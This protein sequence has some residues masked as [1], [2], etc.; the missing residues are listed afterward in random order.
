MKKKETDTF[1]DPQSQEMKSLVAHVKRLN[2]K[3]IKEYKDWCKDNGLSAG[4]HKSS[5]VR[6]KEVD[7]LNNA[8]H[9]YMINKGKHEEKRFGVLYK[10]YCK[11][12]SEDVFKHPFVSQY[13]SKERHYSEKLIFNL[14]KIKED[15]KDFLDFFGFIESV[16]PKILEDKHYNKALSVIF[17]YRPY[18]LFDYKL[19]VPDSKNTQKQFSSLLHH[20]FSKYK[21][22]SFLDQAW[23]KFDNQAIDHSQIEIFLWI[24]SGNNIRT[25]PKLKLKLTKKMANYFMDAP[26]ILDFYQAL[27]YGRVLGLGGDKRLAMVVNESRIARIY[28]NQEFWDSVILFFINNPMLD[29]N[30]I[31]PI[32]DYIFAKKF[33]IGAEFPNFE[34]KG[35]NPNTLLNQVFE[36]HN[37]L[38]KVKLSGNID[39]KPSGVSEYIKEDTV[40]NDRINWYVVELLSSI[41]LKKEGSEQ[42]HCVYSYQNSCQA[43]RCAIFSLRKNNQ[44][45]ATIEVLPNEN[46]IIQ[47]RG[48][49]N[50]LI[51]GKPWSIIEEWAEFSGLTIRC[52]S[53]N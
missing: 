40:D 5:I 8:Y 43:G 14:S 13:F 16:A 12:N 42:R 27:Q 7:F 26:P 22:P 3:S 47:V 2:C 28:K 44:I 38:K 35:K 4:L 1:E 34:I 39:W 32:V 41:D 36:W 52:R 37:H 33:S 21:M 25:F 17:E 19:W 46:T 51:K 24:A 18:W 50:T 9:D 48:K 11:S 29:R 30:Q 31:G 15:E 20:T 10:Q 45:M 53:G 6:Q 49:M 23:V